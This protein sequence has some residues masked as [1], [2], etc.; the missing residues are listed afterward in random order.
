MLKTVQKPQLHFYYTLE[1][2]IDGYVVVAKVTLNIVHV[3]IEKALVH[4]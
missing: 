3:S 2:N 4:M 1:C